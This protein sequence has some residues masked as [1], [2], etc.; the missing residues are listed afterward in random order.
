MQDDLNAGELS[1]RVTIQATTAADAGQDDDGHPVESWT[2]ITDGADV[3]AKIELAAG[4]ERPSGLGPQMTTVYTH[5]VTL[6][7]RGDVTSL[8]R[9]ITDDNRTLNIVRA[10]DPTGRRRRTVCQCCE[11]P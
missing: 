3:P 7:Y 6:R 8:M 10:G 5:R 1:R 9:L 11:A 4:G 2:T